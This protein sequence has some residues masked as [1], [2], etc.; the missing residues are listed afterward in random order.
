MKL[1]E[2]IEK[3]IEKS[4]H[5]KGERRNFHD[6]AEPHIVQLSPLGAWALSNM[7]YNVIKLVAFQELLVVQGG[8]TKYA[9]I[10]SRLDEIQRNKELSLEF[11]PDELKGLPCEGEEIESQYPDP[12]PEVYKI[13]KAEATPVFDHSLTV[14][15]D[16]NP[17][18]VLL[19]G[20][21]FVDGHS[22]VVV[23]DGTNPAVHLDVDQDANKR[24]GPHST[25]R[26]GTI[27]FKVIPKTTGTYRV[28]VVNEFGGLPQELRTRVS[29]VVT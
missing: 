18:E 15:K 22:S 3:L 16:N 14:P 21:G 7:D 26:C 20:Q 1:Y 12:L 6:K 9:A 2:K 5:G 25:F 19:A 24:L 8:D 28:R 27:K 4:T 13:A 23:T 29:L 11:K 17:V 10:S